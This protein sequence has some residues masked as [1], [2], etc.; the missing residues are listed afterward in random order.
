MS[1]INFDLTCGVKLEEYS[2]ADSDF[3][4]VNSW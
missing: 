3:E 2:I 4:F 1:T